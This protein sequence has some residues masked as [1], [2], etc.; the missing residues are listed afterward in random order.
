MQPHETILQHLT[1]GEEHGPFV[2][3]DQDVAQ[4]GHVVLE[5]LED[6]LEVELLEP[7]EALGEEG[8][9][10]V[11]LVVAEAV[12]VLV[13]EDLEDLLLGEQPVAEDGELAEEVGQGLEAVGEVV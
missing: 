1:R 7:V 12:L 5:G 13:E 3:L 10:L 4:D 2:R 11:A 8:E 6:A 9:V